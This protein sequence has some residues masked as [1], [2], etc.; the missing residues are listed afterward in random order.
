MMQ[1]LSAIQLSAAVLFFCAIAPAPMAQTRTVQPQAAGQAVR[2]RQGFFDYA[3]G[4]INL[5][6]TDYGAAMADGR[7]EAVSHTIDD[8]Y[9]W[10]NGVTL[11]LLVCAA[12]IIY[13]E[14]RSAAR[15]EIVAAAIIAELWN[16]RVSDKIEIV[17]RTQQFNQLVELQNQE[18]ERLLSAGPKTSEHEQDAAESITKNV[19]QNEYSGS[20]AAGSAAKSTFPAPRATES[21]AVGNANDGTA[22]LQQSNLMLQRRV[23]ALENSERNLKQRLNQTTILLD[24]ER[25]RNATLK[26][27]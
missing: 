21:A 24:E 3:L 9:F 12:G 4:K 27:A 17:R 14:W 1:R 5:S 7:S 26:G 23:E 8:L 16:G 22:R 6:N 13:F 11:G 20:S 10:S 18:T 2:Q 19:G 25:R 15:K